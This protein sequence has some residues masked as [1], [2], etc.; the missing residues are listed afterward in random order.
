MLQRLSTV[1]S[2]L[3]SRVWV[4]VCLLLVGPGTVAAKEKGHVIERFQAT[5]M[6]LDSGR[7][8]I[9]EI[10]VLEWS[11]D[12][13]R[14]ALIEAFNEG[15]NQGAYEHLGKQDEKAF[16]RLPATLGYQMRYAYNFESDGKRQIVLATDRPIGMGEIMRG[17]DTKEDN[18]SFVVLQLDPE[19]GKGTGEMVFGAEFKVNQKT[20]Q[21]EIETIS[22]NPTKFTTVKTEK[23][24]HKD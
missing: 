5:A 1:H 13:E 10:G 20:G 7:A 4:V 2:H 16:V 23:V 9:V 15:G 14:Q 6:D 18:I 22:M 11:T 8:S 3:R 24:K 19:T 12:E 17:T 21:L